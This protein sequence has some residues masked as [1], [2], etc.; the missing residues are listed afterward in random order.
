M[1]EAQVEQSMLKRGLGQYDALNV[2]IMMP[3]K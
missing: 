3:R 1:A 2:S